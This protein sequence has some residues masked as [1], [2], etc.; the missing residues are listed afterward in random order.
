M[1]SWSSGSVSWMTR[2][3]LI[4]F[5]CVKLAIFL[6]V[7]SIGGLSSDYV[8]V[9]STTH[10][11]YNQMWNK[12]GDV[13]HEHFCCSRK[14]LEMVLA[15]MIGNQPENGISCASTVFLQFRHSPVIRVILTGEIVFVY[16]PTSWF[17]LFLL[18]LPGEDEGI[19]VK[20][21]NCF[22]GIFAW[23]RLRK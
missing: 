17:F 10:F 19:C 5:L 3:F 14:K 13:I 4:H 20:S 23:R 8:D 1:S 21:K 7:V 15:F 2:N 16:L 12:C 6:L 11:T 22:R 9:R 18:H